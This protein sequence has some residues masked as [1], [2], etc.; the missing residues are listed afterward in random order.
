MAN[1]PVKIFTSEELNAYFNANMQHYFYADCK[2][3]YEEFL[4]HSDGKKPLNIIDKQRPNEPD[5]VKE[6]RLLIWEPITKPTVSRVINSL[7]KIRRSSDW[8]IVYPNEKFDKIV[9][10]EE[11]E[12]YCEKDFPYFTSLTNYIFNVILKQY[13]I[14]SN[15]VI[16]IAPLVTEGL[17]PTDYLSPFPYIY[18]C[19]EVLDFKAEEYAVLEIAAG[20]TYY[21]NKGKLQNGRSFYVANTV[22]IQR[23]DQIDSKKNF[24]LAL[25][26]QHNLG[27]LP[28]FKLGGI[29]CDSEQNNFIYE[30]RISGMLPNLNEAVAEYTDLQAG[31]RLNIY[32][33]RWEFT[34][35]E[36]SKCKGTGLLVNPNWKNGDALEMRQI[37]CGNCH[38]GYIPSGPYS[39]LLIRPADLGQQALPTPPAGYIEKDINIIKLMDESVDKHIYKAL[40]AINFQFLEDTPLN[41]SGTAKEVDK[42]ELNNTVH[43]IAEDL[44]ALMDKLYKTIAYYRYLGIYPKDEVDKMLPTIPVPEHYDLISSQYMQDEIKRARDAKINPMLIS[45]MEVEYS[46]KRFAQDPE[47]NQ[48]IKLVHVLDPLPGSTVDDKLAMAANKTITREN[49]IISD[50]LVWYVRRAL[51]ENPEFDTWA[52]DKQME[53]MNKYALEQITKMDEATKLIAAALAGDQNDGTA[54]QDNST[55]AD[56]PPMDQSAGPQQN[57]NQPVNANA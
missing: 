6:F 40:A 27:W 32:P 10:G 1:L 2:K 54:V 5:V 17:E 35:H 25:D 34:Q 28:A 53:L 56:N 51:F 18:N 24:T 20:C 48:V 22:S 8:A 14:D 44:I 52:Y 46:A 50:N 3:K 4:P 7:G 57:N 31:K 55:E 9:E 13:L 11:L 41:Q 12:D 16:F 39:K 38:N 33:E 45:Q 49:N 47:V 21:D 37:K 15:A 19:C 42:E 36:C 43:A 30:S 26:Y 29:I 23:Y